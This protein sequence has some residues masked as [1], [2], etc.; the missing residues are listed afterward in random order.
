MENYVS[1]GPGVAVSFRVV[2]PGMRGRLD[3]CSARWLFQNCCSRGRLRLGG[4]HAD[5]G[6]TSDNAN[7]Q[8][9]HHLRVTVE[10]VRSPMPG[11]QSLSAPPA[12]SSASLPVPACT[13]NFNP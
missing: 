12:C 2:E 9:D 7:S 6:D 5:H 3:W 1:L 11:D 13:S 8:G 10:P 4:Q